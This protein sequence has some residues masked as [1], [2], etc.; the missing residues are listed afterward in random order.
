MSNISDSVCYLTCTYNF[1][2]LVT[3]TLSI[4]NEFRTLTSEQTD[5]GFIVYGDISFNDIAACIHCVHGPIVPKIIV[6]PSL[7]NLLFKWKM[8]RQIELDL[9]Q[10]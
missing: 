9:V 6:A 8:P 7:S 3:S 10:I 1:N 4:S 5:K 2:Y